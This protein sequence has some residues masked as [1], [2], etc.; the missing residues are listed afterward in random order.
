VFWTDSSQKYI[1]IAAP[2]LVAKLWNQPRCPTTDEMIKKMWYIWHIMEYY[3]A[4]KKNVIGRKKW[5]ELE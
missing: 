3:S 5:M 1:F 4:I 2:F